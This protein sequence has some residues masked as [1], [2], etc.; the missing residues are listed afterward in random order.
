MISVVIPVHN[1]EAYLSE[2]IESVLNQTFP[3]S[4]ILVIDEGSTDDTP[5]V[6]HAYANK[7]RYVRQTQAG[8]GSARDLGIRLSQTEFIAFLDADDVWMPEKLSLQM[9]AFTEQ[10]ELGLVF[11]HMVQFR[12]PDL[13][14][15]VAAQIQC[16][17]APQPSPLISCLLARRS[18][19]E[20]V[21]LLRTDTLA[22]FVD[23]YL[24]AR[25]A[26]LRMRFVEEVLV[27]RRLH[28][29]NLTRR[30]KGVRREYLQFLK[31]SLDRRRAGHADA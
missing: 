23:W 15:D 2:A 16:D 3:P 29:S 18:A 12:S 31:A 9:R 7:V 30:N 24:R 13:P 6:A 4:Q 27:R 26:G 20:Q 21:G 8:P 28:A 22:E 19:F 10:P 5:V 14:A 25:D 1:G 17:D 11:C